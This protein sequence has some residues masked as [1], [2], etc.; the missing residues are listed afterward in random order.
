MRLHILGSSSSG[1]CYLLQSEKT[2]EVLAIEAGVRFDKVQRAL[3]YDLQKVVGCC[4]SHEHGDHAKYAADMLAHCI[5]VVCSEGTAKTLH[6]QGSHFTRIV[7]AREIVRLGD[8]QVIPFP[9]QHDAAEPF[10]YF[11]RHEECGTVL[12]ATDTYYLRFKFG[13]LNNLMVECN[14]RQD[15]LDENIKTGRVPAAIRNR[16]IKS[17]MSYDT[18]LEM[19][20]ANDLTK[21]NNIILIH[22]SSDNSHAS[23][24][25]KGIAGATHKN[26]MAAKAGMVIDFNKTPY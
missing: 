6:I 19:L 21:V 17:H 2:G 20:L 9:V 13:G 14:Y 5:T 18:C 16:I 23:E 3:D 11:I 12:F 4:I 7:R 1:N 8:F 24:F 15:I 22:L 26:V 10:G 25:V